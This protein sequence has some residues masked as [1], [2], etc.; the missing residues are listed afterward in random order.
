MTGL[1]VM[2]V[3]GDPESIPGDEHAI[4]DDGATVRVE[5]HALRLKRW[6][7]RGAAELARFAAGQTRRRH[8]LARALDRDAELE[9]Q[10][11]PERRR[12]EIGARDFFADARRQE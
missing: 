8:G 1:C 11:L 3:A 5:R 2:K 10:H 7:P 12:S 4:E 9:L 6:R